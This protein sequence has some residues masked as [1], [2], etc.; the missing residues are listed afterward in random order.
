MVAAFFCFERGEKS[1][2]EIRGNFRKTS[3]NLPEHVR[4]NSASQMQKT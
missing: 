3:G 2:A 1:E 4:F